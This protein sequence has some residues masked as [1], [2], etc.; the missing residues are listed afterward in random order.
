M[1][2]A[3]S[4]GSVSDKESASKAPANAM[5]RMFTVPRVPQDAPISD[6]KGTWV[7]ADPKT[8][9]GMSA[10]GYFFGRDLQANL[11]V[12]VG[13]ISSNVGGTRAE[14]WTSRETLLASP[15][16][17]PMVEAH[18][19][20]MKKFAAD[21]TAKS[22][23]NANSVSALYNGMIAPITPYT[24]RGAIWY[25]GE[26]NVGQAYN[27]RTLFPM[28]IQNWR[29]DWGQDFPFYFVQLAPFHAVK[30]DPGES[31]WAELCEAQRL[32]AKKVPNTGMAVI[33][34]YGHE[35]DIHPTPKQPVG[36]RLALIARAKTYG[37]KVEYSGPEFEGMK[38]EGNKAI[39]R[40]SHADGLHTREL[41]ATDTRGKGGSAWRVK[42]G[43]TGAPV[44]GFT[45]AGADHRFH[46]A[47]A[48]IEGDTVVVWAEGVSTPVAVRY[49]WADYPLVNLF[50]K[51]GLPASPFRTD[52]FPVTTQ[53]KK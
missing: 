23:L 38:I 31:A 40:F 48:K 14:A 35:A 6:A 3:V 16:Y 44:M 45:V 15:L 37:E 13:L 18:V 25:Q 28:M 33:T 19:A 8:V 4:Q 11:K 21:R 30:K 24:I 32:T 29:K 1:Q 22:P 52:E 49:G 50:N 5:L 41:V 36:E 17:K 26:S 9:F 12:H 34:D 2:W 39:L 46:N 27:Y 53:P 10:V 20:A 7:G 51:A 43:V 47:Q 42:P